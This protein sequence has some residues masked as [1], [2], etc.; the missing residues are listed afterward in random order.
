MIDPWSVTKDVTEDRPVARSVADLIR[1][2][3]R[4]RAAGRRAGP[5]GVGAGGPCVSA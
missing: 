5:G 3:E 4:Q 1:Y 2:S